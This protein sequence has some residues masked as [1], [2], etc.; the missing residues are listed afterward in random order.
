M[1]ADFQLFGELWDKYNSLLPVDEYEFDQYMKIIT[2]I[3]NEDFDFSDCKPEFIIL[4][5]D[6]YQTIDNI[7][8]LDKELKCCITIKNYILQKTCTQSS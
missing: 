1:N 3:R 8:E 2:K 5:Y 7:G 6:M 4:L